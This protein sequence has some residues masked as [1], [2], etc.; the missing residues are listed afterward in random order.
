MIIT[1]KNIV[2]KIRDNLKYLF[3]N[4]YRIFIISLCLFL[5]YLIF[6]FLETIDQSILDLKILIFLIPLIL[7]LI[8]LLKEIYSKSTFLFLLPFLIVV[9]ILELFFGSWNYTTQLT[10]VR[11]FKETTLILN[12]I[13]YKTN[14]DRKI[15]IY[16]N[17]FGFRGK[18]KNNSIDNL[19]ILTVGGSTTVQSTLTD[20]KTFQDILSKLF[21]EKLDKEIYVLN[22]GE[23]AHS[24]KSHIHSLNNRFK[25]LNIKPKYFL[26][27][28]GVNEG[29]EAEHFDRSWNIKNQLLLRI[30]NS[31]FIVNKILEVRLYLGTLITNPIKFQKWHLNGYLPFEEE[32]KSENYIFINKDKDYENNL[33]EKLKLE[34]DNTRKNILELTRIVNSEY[35]AKAIFVTNKKALAFKENNSIKVFHKPIF[36]TSLIGIGKN[37]DIKINYYLTKIISDNIID[38]CKENVKNICLNL[39]DEL[40]LNNTDFHDFAH[41]KPS[42]ALKIGSYLF[43]NLKNE[44]LQ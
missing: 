5:I 31:S 37:H 38:A 32:L 4:K 9:F 12:N 10:D 39:N 29:I 44:I 36:D 28:I 27:F 21:K 6:K 42:G 33:T 13:W 20:G 26:F 25:K 7:L 22:A 24:T 1:K 16:L 2:V 30:Y 23:D 8:S 35:N 43:E 14:E 41:H 18:L 40:D 19:D 15:Q 34:L 11:K 17:K 3:I